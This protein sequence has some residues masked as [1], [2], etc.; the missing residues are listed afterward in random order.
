MKKLKKISMVLICIMSLMMSVIM[1]SAAEQSYIYSTN[2]PG[3][4]VVTATTGLNVRESAST[5]ATIKT[6][7]AFNSY[8]M[9]IGQ[10]GNWYYV[11]Y[12]AN[13]STG[14][15]SKDYVDD[16]SNPYILQVLLDD[17]TLNFRST[18]ST[19]GTRLASIPNGKMIPYHST[20]STD[21]IAA[22]YGNDLGYVSAA[23]VL[24][25]SR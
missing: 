12:D 13:G 11:Q 23:W 25:C 18:P 6:S 24:V 2:N 19:S 1:V 10:S 21:W 15:V 22:V 8:I 14:Y 9:I 17:G 5:T 4:G 7:L 3:Y 16:Q 20:Y